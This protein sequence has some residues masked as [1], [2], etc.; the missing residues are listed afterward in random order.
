MNIDI[1]STSFELTPSLKVYINKKLVDSLSK[2]IRKYDNEGG[3]EMKIEVARTTKHH[4]KGQV[5]MAEVNLIL[6]GKSIRVVER[7]DDIRK[8]IDLTKKVLKLKLE[9]H[10]EKITP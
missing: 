9:Q 1:K 2:M 10:K 5:Y 8:A 4:Y 6:P 7:S 3:V